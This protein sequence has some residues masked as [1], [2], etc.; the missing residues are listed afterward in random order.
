MSLMKNRSFSFPSGEVSVREDGFREAGLLIFTYNKTLAKMQV[1]V[2]LDFEQ[3]YQLKTKLL[4]SGDGKLQISRAN[5]QLESE[6]WFEWT[7]PSSAL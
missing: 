1:S 7:A 4:N 6:F 2:T 5:F 3:R